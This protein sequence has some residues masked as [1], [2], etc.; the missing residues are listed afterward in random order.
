MVV[1]GGSDGDKGIARPLCG[2]VASGEINDVVAHVVDS[3]LTRRRAGETFMQFV[4]ALNDEELASLVDR[5]V[6]AA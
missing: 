4:R 6:L 1:G 5:P 2:P 3:W